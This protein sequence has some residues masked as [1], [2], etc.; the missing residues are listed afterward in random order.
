MTSCVPYRGQDRI[1]EP[2]KNIALVSAVAAPPAL[3]PEIREML[4]TSIYGAPLGVSLHSE[5]EAAC[6][7]LAAEDEAGRAWPKAG[8]Y[9]GYTSHASIYDLPNRAPI[10]AALVENIDRLIAAFAQAVEF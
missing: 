5:L 9:R 8:L 1:S 2:S 7:K 10:F 3:Q 4:D 6:L